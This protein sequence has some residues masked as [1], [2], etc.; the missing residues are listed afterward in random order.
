[1][2]IGMISP[3]LASVPP[4]SYGG[5]ELVVSLLVEELV[6]RG[7]EVTLF[8]SGD[9]QTKA[10]LVSI[11]EYRYGISGSPDSDRWMREIR[12]IVSC[13]QRADEFDIIHNH[14]SDEGM[15]LAPLSRAPFLTTFHTPVDRQERILSF[16]SY[17]GWYNTVSASA[18]RSLP[19]KEDDKFMGVIY[20]AIDW[21][22]YPFNEEEREGYLLFLAAI[23]S[24]KGTHLAIEVALRLHRKLIIAGPVFDPSKEYFRKE[25]EPWV[26]GKQIV[27][28]G[29]ADYQQKRQLLSEADCLLVPIQWEEPFGLYFIEAMACGTPVVAFNR[30]SAPE[31]IEN[32]KTGY[33]VKDI[34]EMIAAVKNIPYINRAFC[35]KYVMDRFSIERM[36][37]GYERAYEDIVLLSRAQEEISQER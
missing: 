3:L 27:Y 22:S 35:R 32:G 23:G 9:S 10:K 25:V 29:E 19:E 11:S 24:H 6:R 36:V 17:Q 34:P 7:H 13:L 26:D 31:V 4:K 12:N 20:N 18:K 5:T 14:A 37:D 8:A 33:V 16:L 21:E 15:V 1:M 30:G 28:F 2:R